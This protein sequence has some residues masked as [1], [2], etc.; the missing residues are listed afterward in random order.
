MNIRPIAYS[1][2]GLPGAEKSHNGKYD[3][4]TWPDL[5]Q[6]PY[7]IELGTKYN[8]NSIQI[9]LNWGLAKGHVVIPK[10]TGLDHQQENLAV[11]D[12]RLTDDEIKKVDELD[13]NIRGC[14]KFEF[15]EG[16]DCF[17]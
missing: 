1:P 3:N 4:G 11:F 6:E 16:F 13:R 7:L 2:I 14:N 15:L 9:M 10:A 5:R 17:A 8:K 12:F